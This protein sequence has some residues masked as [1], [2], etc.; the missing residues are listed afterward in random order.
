MRCFRDSIN[1]LIL[2]IFEN[3]TLKARAVEKTIPTKQRGRI[4]FETKR[5]QKK[6]LIFYHIQI[7]QIK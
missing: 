1:E 3:E 6:K 5:E 2:Y 7:S 4:V